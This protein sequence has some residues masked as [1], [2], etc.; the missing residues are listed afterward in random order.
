MDDYNWDEFD[1]QSNEYLNSDQYQGDMFS[2]PDG[3]DWGGF[4]SHGGVSGQSNYN[5]D[6]GNSI[7]QD[8]FKFG[9]YGQ[10]TGQQFNP[11][12]GFQQPQQYGQQQQ[13]FENPQTGGEQGFDW[14]KLGNNLLGGLGTAAM[15]ASKSFASNATPYLQRLFQGGMNTAAASQEKKSNQQMATQIPQTVQNTLQNQRQFASPYDTASTAATNQGANSMRDLMQQKLATAMQDPY[16]SPIVKNQVDQIN[17]AQ[18]RIDAKAGRRSNL[19]GSAPATLAASAQVAQKY[20]DSLQN[21]AGANINPYSGGLD[22]ALAA[23]MQGLKYGA[24]GNSPYFSAAGKTYND[25]VYGSNP[26]MDKIME[27]LQSKG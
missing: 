16:S 25:Q 20:I 5:F 17:E 27:F 12:G 13:N 2:T 6:L 24:Q 23:Q 1:N 19:A 4:G 11:M 7:P 10:D 15:G 14:S 26:Q 8:T 9:S 21:P 3:Q 18:R 22:A